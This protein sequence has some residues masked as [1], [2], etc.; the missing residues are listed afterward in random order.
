M[1]NLTRKIV[2]ALATLSNACP[3]KEGGSCV[4]VLGKCLKCGGS[5]S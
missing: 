5:E 4:Y 1:K 2:Q 3:S